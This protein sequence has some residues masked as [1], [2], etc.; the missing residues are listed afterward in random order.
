MLLD[1][2]VE[3][4]ARRDAVQDMPLRVAVVRVAWPPSVRF[5]L[6]FIILDGDRLRAGG[7]EAVER[8][9]GG[10]NRERLLVAIS[11]LPSGRGVLHTPPPEPPGRRAHDDGPA[12]R[13]H[14]QRY[15]FC[16]GGGSGGGDGLLLRLP[17]VVVGGHFLLNRGWW[18][19]RRPNDLISSQPP[20]FLDVLSKVEHALKLN[21]P[22]MGCTLENASTVMNA[23]TRQRLRRFR[24]GLNK[25]RSG[26]AQLQTDLAEARVEV[27]RNEQTIAAN[28]AAA[29]RGTQANAVA[30]TQI[31]ELEWELAQLQRVRSQQESTIALQTIELGQ[32]Q[33]TSTELAAARARL[34][35]QLLDAKAAQHRTAAGDTHAQEPESPTA[36]RHEY[37]DPVPAASRRL[38]EEIASVLGVAPDCDKN[39]LKQAIF[40]FG[41]EALRKRTV[42]FLR[43]LCQFTGGAVQFVSPKSVTADHLFHWAKQWALVEVE[44]EL[45]VEDAQRF[46]ELLDIE[47]QAGAGDVEAKRGEE[48]VEAEAEPEVEMSIDDDGDAAA[49]SVE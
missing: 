24:L 23:E 33:A 12:C 41:D 14:P 21:T 18:W 37:S 25:V 29:S 17:M 20:D 7:G 35:Q 11:R 19:W 28:R 10:V 42:Q 8:G 34:Q 31:R 15:A 45:P 48:Q 44:A 22:L 1:L 27:Q 30:S 26:V 47:D 5:L 13:P 40:R 3:M 6:F 43:E 46:T 32:I 16:L 4:D 49:E 36:V 2:V 9:G 39:T 38:P